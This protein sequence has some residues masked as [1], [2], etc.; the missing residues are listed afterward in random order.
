MNPRVHDRPLVV[1]PSNP[2]DGIVPANAVRVL[3]RIELRDLVEHLGVVLE[4]L[5]AVRE[6]GRHVQHP[7]VFRGEDD[8]KV[9]REGPRLRAQIEDH[10]V[11]RAARAADDLRLG[12]GRLLIVHAAQCALSLV[13]GRTALRDARLEAARL[14]LAPAPRPREAPARVLDRLGL[15]DERARERRL[16]ED[17]G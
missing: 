10:V 16:D 1:R 11:D 14:E 17:H 8:R 7:A 3:G 12:E 2:E 13:E 9:P 4:R 5:E 6:P 15:D